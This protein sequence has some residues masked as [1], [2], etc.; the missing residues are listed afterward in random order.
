ME[1]E[2][3]TR[4][5]PDTAPAGS[6]AAGAQRPPE[7]RLLLPETR[8]SFT[9]IFGGAGLT[10]VVFVVL[11]VLAAWFRPDRQIQ[12]RMP[13]ILPE[14][15]VWL[16]QPGP[17][18]GGGGGGNKSPEPPKAEELPAVKPPDPPPEPVPQPEPE[19]EPEIEPEIIP[20]IAAITPTEAPAVIGPPPT[21]S[22]A[23]L[24]T[25]TDGGAGTGKGGGIGPG[26]GD[27]LG[28]GIGGGTGGDVYRV[29]NGV[30]AP[31]PLYSQKPLY[32]SE[33]MLRRVQ[34]EAELDCIVLTDGTVGKCDVV[35]PL[36]SNQFGLDNEALKAAKKWRFRPGTR[37]GQP[38]NVLVRIILEF[39]MR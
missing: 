30:N 11:V 18:G 16:E 25:G 35:K 1:H 5:T 39:N 23:S 22:T 17:G 31:T 6:P 12:A 28:E 15:I 21:A 2:H 29:G 27:G 9:T 19:P 32:T 26:D 14:D 33:A 38:V 34:G 37:Q 20:Q 8:T 36:D 3:T 10:H 24:G 7:L 13:D 4:G